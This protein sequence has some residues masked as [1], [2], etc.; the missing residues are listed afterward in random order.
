MDKDTFFKYFWLFVRRRPYKKRMIGN[1]S[2]Y[3]H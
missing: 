2:V 3:R 1:S